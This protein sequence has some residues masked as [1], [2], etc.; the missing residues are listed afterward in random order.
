MNF[1]LNQR[2]VVTWIGILLT[3]VLVVSLVMGN[4]IALFERMEHDLYD[5]RLVEHGESDI[6]NRIVIVDIDEA[7]MRAEGRWPWSR[8][9]LALLLSQLYERY[10]V[11][12]V[13]FDMVFS[14][15]D[16][17]ISQ[18]TLQDLYQQNPD[19]TLSDLVYLS[20]QQY[21]DLSFADAIG[22]YGAVLGYAFD[23]NPE[24]MT[25]LGIT[26]PPVLEASPDLAK[27][28]LP[29][30]SSVIGNLAILQ[31][32][33]PWGGFF[34]NPV[35]DSDG[36]YRRVPILQEYDG[37]YYPSLALATL[38]A[39]FGEP[40]VDLTVEYDATGEFA[41][42]SQVHLAGIPI[43]VDESGAVLVPYR[44]PA[45]S[46][47]YVSATDV[48][49]GKADESVLNGAIVLVGT[50]AAGLL[51]LRVTPYGDLYPGVEVHANIVGGVLDERILSKPDYTD[52]IQ[53]IQLLVVGLVLSILL[54][55]LS[56]VWA[57]VLT[58]SFIVI[59]VAMNLYF[60]A[61]FKWVVPLAYTLLLTLVIYIFQQT[62][63][64][65]YESR[66][67]RHLASVF[68]QYIPPEIVSE[69]NTEGAD[70]QLR[71]ESRDMT[72]FFS[73]VR[74]FTSLS[75]A[76]TPNQL[77][78]LMNTYL[79]PMTRIVHDYRGTVDK[80]IGDALMAFWG[81]P[82]NDPKHPENAM[83]A[84]LEMQTELDVVNAKLAEEGLPAIA[85]GM[86]L[87][88]GTMNVGN[89]GSN[90]RMAYT[91]MGDAVN[92]GS[93]LEGL[94][95]FYGVPIIVSGELRAQLSGYEFLELDK[96]RVKGREEP[97][98][99]YMPLG[100]RKDVSQNQFMQVKRFENV[101]I[102][103]RE[104]QWQQAADNL[105]QFAES[106][107]KYPGLV[108]LYRERIAQRLAAGQ[109]V[110]DWDYVFTHHEK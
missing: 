27:T 14:E 73:D 6:D 24:N 5:W 36:V 75:E 62:S 19:L 30:A 64:Y 42:L 69:L 50:S 83:N 17:D 35:V 4:R 33:T 101:L 8:D 1:Q 80:Y 60:W 3:I 53:L 44:G 40:S 18:F 68:G 89:M 25:P 20:E 103:Y 7:T 84:A 22:H 55:R 23:H 63:G 51:D 109:A 79:T 66:N 90:F 39:L 45:G 57:A 12:V 61:A 81:A 38:M 94:T 28:G 54:P 34:D 29:H 102:A 48:L 32:A 47:P 78:R 21:T 107:A 98:V 110:G 59:L 108:A 95:K 97:V 99:L 105:D 104:G 46:F 41:S 86:G 71:G 31:E 74:G 82:I 100:R 92:L 13:G 96:V 67:R 16:T 72:V 106:T 87:H 9:K 91:V 37:A 52:A 85:V 58:L 93:R 88:T 15:A 65:F 49:S 77:T 56:V 10:Q 11:S 26:G 43:P 2:M 70:A 76:L